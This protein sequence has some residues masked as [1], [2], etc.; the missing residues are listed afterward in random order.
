MNPSQSSA[1]QLSNIEPSRFY[2]DYSESDR[3]AW[4]CLEGFSN[5]S[6]KVPVFM[7]DIDSIPFFLQ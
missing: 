1:V 2:C 5:L 3:Q 4:L 6:L 7:V